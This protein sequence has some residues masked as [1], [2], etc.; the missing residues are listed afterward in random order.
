MLILNRFCLCYLTPAPPMQ[1]RITALSFRLD[2]PFLRAL[3]PTDTLPYGLFYVIGAEF[4]G[5]HVRFSDV[6]R[7][8]IRLVSV[9]S[10]GR[11]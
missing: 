1:P 5:F 4:R 9:S 2:P 11:G 3:Y 10:R 8:G 6:A 7:G